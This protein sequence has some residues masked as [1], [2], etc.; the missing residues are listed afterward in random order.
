MNFVS[1]DQSLTF[2]SWIQTALSESGRLQIIDLFCYWD[3]I[4]IPSLVFSFKTP[5]VLKLED[6]RLD[7]ICFVDLPFLKILHLERIIF[8]IEDDPSQILSGCPNL[9]DLKF[10]DLS[11]QVKGKF[12]RLSK[13]VRASVDNLLISLE[14][15]KEAEVLRFDWL[16]GLQLSLVLYLNFDFNNLVQLQLTVF[17]DWLL[18]FKVLNH[19][20]KL[21]SFVMCIYKNR[22]EDEDVWPYQKLFLLAFHH[23]LKPVVLNITMVLKMSFN[24]QDIY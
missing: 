5:V 22:Y 20:P 11:S 8:P 9:E 17:P 6:T 4:V 24:L 21:Q 3:N 1:R 13:L 16:F 18:V 23:T 10:R 7:H 12:I 19:C 2:K 14:T 15:F